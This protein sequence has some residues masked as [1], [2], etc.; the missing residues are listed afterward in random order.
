MEASTKVEEALGVATWKSRH[1]IQKNKQKLEKPTSLEEYQHGFPS[2][3]AG[4]FN[5]F[6]TAL[7]KKKYEVVTKKR[8]QRG[9]QVKAFDTIRVTKIVVFLI[10][11]ILNIAFPGTNIWLTHI[12]SF[13]C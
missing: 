3:L 7:Q 6:I 9:L 8:I 1:K 4:F 5:G 10:S 2:C 11:V 13:L 12:M